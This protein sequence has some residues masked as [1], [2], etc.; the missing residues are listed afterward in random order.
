MQ[1]HP[2]ASVKDR[3]SQKIQ[4]H[5]PEVVIFVQA[6]FMTPIFFIYSIEMKRSSA[7]ITTVVTRKA[8]L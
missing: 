7:L 8:L 2:Q 1:S 4:R 5:A 6:R 3:A